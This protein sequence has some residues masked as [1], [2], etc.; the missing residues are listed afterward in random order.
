MKRIDFASMQYFVAVCETGSIARAAEREHIVP[1]AVSKRLGELEA[2]FGVPLL[3]RGARGVSPTVAGEALL[4][5]A[6]DVLRSVDRLHAELSEYALG[7]RGRVSIHANISAV[8]EFL[9]EDLRSFMAAHEGI[10]IDL[11]E[12]LSTDILRAVLEGRTDLGVVSQVHGLDGLECFPYRSD[13]LVAIVRPEHPLAGAEITSYATSL[14]F[15]HVG[16][17]HNSSLYSLLEREAEALG[18]TRR[19]RIHV[20]GFDAVCRMVE[21]GL[22]VGI[23][24]ERVGGFFAAA[25]GLRIVRLDDAWAR[26]ELQLVVRDRSC[27]SVAARLLLDHLL[28][29]DATP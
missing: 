27:L 28:G 22:G 26:R 21:V 8:V 1:S 20:S 24:P 9:P 18:L 3:D 5:H 23:V 11:Q 15:D 6:R 12:H 7:V 25:L 13:E 2:L 4:F 29:R 10:K 16:L 14:A 17:S 19:L